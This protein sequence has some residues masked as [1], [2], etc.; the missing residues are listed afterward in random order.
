MINH[1]LSAR[2]EFSLL[3]FLITASPPLPVEV[4]AAALALYKSVNREKKDMLKKSNKNRLY[5][6]GSGRKGGSLRN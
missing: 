5:L 1:T 2:L 3:L 6:E 4:V